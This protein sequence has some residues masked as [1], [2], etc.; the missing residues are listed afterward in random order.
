[1][2]RSLQTSNHLKNLSKNLGVLCSS[3]KKDNYSPDIKTN[4]ELIARLN[5]LNSSQRKF[6]ILQRCFHHKE[7]LHHKNRAAAFFLDLSH[8]SKAF[9]DWQLVIG[10]WH[11][12]ST[13]LVQTFNRFSYPITFKLYNSLS[14]TIKIFPLNDPCPSGISFSTCLL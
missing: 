12:I 14:N 4:I 11:S 6:R 8:P 13:D 7:I 2:I 1:M 5:T 3:L 10:N 9:D